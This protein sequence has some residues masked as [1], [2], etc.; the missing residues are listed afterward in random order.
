MF[1]LMNACFK[2]Y[3]LSAAFRISAAVSL[4]AG[5]I[6]GVLF[7]A[8]SSESLLT[9][10]VP[11]IASVALTVVNI[12]KEWEYRTFANKLTVGH[13]KG[14]I[15][16]SELGVAL[17]ADAAVYLLF[18]LGFAA[19]VPKNVFGIKS[20]ALIRI[21]AMMMFAGLS[22]CAMS[23]AVSFMFKSHNS[24]LIIS[25]AAIFGMFAASEM[26]YTFIDTNEY[27]A[28]F[29]EQF[30]SNSVADPESGDRTDLITGIAVKEED[31]APNGFVKLAKTAYALNPIGALD[32]YSDE[33]RPYLDGGMPGQY[34]LYPRSLPLYS[35][36]LI[37]LFTAAGYAAFSGKNVK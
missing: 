27:R 8:G 28:M 5:V 12:S 25:F 3:L 15:F 22:L 37:A 35:L 23:A 6:C 17:A 24:A 34:D 1:N 4:I 32:L 19:A 10:S 36:F 11:V 13:T 29:Y 20:T 21:P 16:L 9:A 30:M 18:G 33:I 14:K 7:R 2:K 31:Y 26:L